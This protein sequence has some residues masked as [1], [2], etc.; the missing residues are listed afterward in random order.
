MISTGLPGAFKSEFDL[1]EYEEGDGRFEGT[2]DRSLSHLQLGLSPVMWVMAGV[3]VFFVLY[4]LTCGDS[5]A[6]SFASALGAGGVGVAVGSLCLRG[7]PGYRIF[8]ALILAAY[9]LRSLAGVGFYLNSRDASYFDSN[10]KYVDANWEF[11]WTYQYVMMAA[12]SVTKKGEWRPTRIFDEKLDK[13]PFIHA[14]MGYFMAAGGGRNAL[15]LTPFNAF[16]HAVA[17]ILIACAALACGYSQLVSLY[18]GGIVAWIPW[19][20][21]G[22]LMWRDSVGFAWVVLAVLLLCIGKNYGIMGGLFFAIPAGFLAWADRS[23]YLMAIALIALLSMVFDQQKAISASWVKIL[24]LLVVAVV[25]GVVV[26]KLGHGIQ[27]LAVGKYERQTGGLGSRV[28]MLPLLVLRALAGPFPWFVGG[29]FDPYVLCDYLFHVLQ[30]AVFLAYLRN[31]RQILWRTTLLTYS[32]A[33]FWGVGL[34]AGGVHTAYLA[35]AFPFVL[36]VV[37]DSGARL[38][39]YLQVSAAFF[40]LAN[41]AYVALGLSGS[42]LVLGTT[43]Y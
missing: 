3:G 43:G 27:S 5:P 41:V 12:D 40:A 20:F 7:L 11:R 31:W 32:A 9:L 28:I 19:G 26:W 34:I 37:L 15:D 14:W 22:S 33:I 6:A 16:H 39:G 35:V 36:P 8:L 38:R 18:S 4:A 30:F 42:G 10:G 24:R 1:P 23:P 17:G 2:W 13:N 25:M 21:A 29:K